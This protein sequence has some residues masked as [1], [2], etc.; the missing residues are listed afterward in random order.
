M[1]PKRPGTALRRRDTGVVNSAKDIDGN[2]EE[3]NNNTSDTQQA[4]NA[5]AAETVTTPPLY[6]PGDYIECR[7]P[8]WSDYFKGYVNQVGENNTYTVNF[9]DGERVT[10]ISENLCVCV[11]A[12]RC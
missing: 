4:A 9:D 5:L 12:S 7:L 1:P 8:Q 6:T 10:G 3:V 11:C 2:N